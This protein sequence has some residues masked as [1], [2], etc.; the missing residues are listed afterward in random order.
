M[1]HY[2]HCIQSASAASWGIGCSGALHISSLPPVVPFIFALL[3]R[4]PKGRGLLICCLSS[5]HKPKPYSSSSTQSGHSDGRQPTINEQYKLCI[6]FLV[7]F[8][9]FQ[10]FF[11]FANI[12]IRQ[13]DHESYVYIFLSCFTSTIMCMCVRDC[14]VAVELWLQSAR[15]IVY[16]YAFL[17]LTV[18]YDVPPPPTG[19]EPGAHTHLKKKACCLCCNNSTLWLL[20]VMWISSLFCWWYHMLTL[21]VR[22]MAW[23]AISKT[24]GIYENTHAKLNP[25]EGKHVYF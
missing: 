13:H 21:L 6:Y 18:V 17:N 8:F 7:L 20:C 19:P 25:C 14:K 23:I 11:L 9:F 22:C 16:V 1:K 12:L 4:K 3:L 24:S 15:N 5:Y 2:V 10:L